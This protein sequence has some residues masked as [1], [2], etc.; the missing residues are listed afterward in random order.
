MIAYLGNEECVIIQLPR[1][2]HA[3]AASNQ[4]DLQETALKALIERLRAASLADH[5]S[6]SIQMKFGQ[7]NLTCYKA[8]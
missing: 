1:G 2:S 5:M 6:R 7:N 8:D 4:I 3:I